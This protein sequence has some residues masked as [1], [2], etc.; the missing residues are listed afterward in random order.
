MLLAALL[1]GIVRAHSELV[2]SAPAGGTT[3]T[4][5]PLEITGDFSEPM[6]PPRSSMELRDPDGRT[7]AMGGVPAAGPDTRMAITGLPA[8]PA[9]TYEVRWT[10]VT[11]DDNGVGRGTFSFTV[12]PP[13]SS[14]TANGASPSPAP[15]AAPGGG[16]SSSA[17]VLIPL[18]L[19]VA[20]LAGGAIWLLRRR[21]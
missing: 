12:A 21:R 18:L 8:L 3:L 15:S 13:S 11:P 17:D 19:L 1:P 5:S 6:D 2:T 7:I 14:P 10:T 16:T 20:V 4:A 9:G